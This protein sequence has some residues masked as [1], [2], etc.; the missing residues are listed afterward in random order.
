MCW[1]SYLISHEMVQASPLF[2]THLSTLLFNV[3]EL[4]IRWA[5]GIVL[6]QLAAEDWAFSFTSWKRGCF[7]HPSNTGL[8]FTVLRPILNNLKEVRINQIESN[9]SPPQDQS[10]M[11]ITPKV[12]GCQA[13][14]DGFPK[15]SQ[16]EK[17]ET[18]EEQV[19]ISTPLHKWYSFVF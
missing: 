4:I 16:N 9:Q 14:S 1:L 18:N 19:Q 12:Y 13:M 6:R 8:S 3:G 2:S 11:S 5:S 17:K 10:I 7:T 15:E